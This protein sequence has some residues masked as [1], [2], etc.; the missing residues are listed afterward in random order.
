[1][2]NETL[3]QTLS[4]LLEEQLA[5]DPAYYLVDLKIKPTNNIKVFVEG[6]QGITIEKCVAINRKFY[7][8]LEELGLFPDNDFS[9]E[10]SSPGLDEPLKLYRQYRRNIGRPVEVILNDGTKVEGKLLD[11]QE[12]RIVVEEVKGGNKKK[13]TILHNLLFDH[14]K[15][16][17]IQ[18]VF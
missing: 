8:K 1:M 6:D 5:E 3:I 11:A 13:E 16:T 4:G 12:S 10:V 18:V 2:A 17:K 15:S 14:I 9:L 7:R